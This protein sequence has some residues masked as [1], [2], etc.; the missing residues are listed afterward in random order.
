[1]HVCDDSKDLHIKC[2][3]ETDGESEPDEDDEHRHHCRVS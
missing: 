3:A 2:N 1:M